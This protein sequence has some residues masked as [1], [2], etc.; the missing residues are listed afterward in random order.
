MTKEMLGP[1]IT[2]PS[3]IIMTEGT[4]GDG[5]ASLL[6][7]PLTDLFLFYLALYG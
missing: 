5:P 3:M 4:N 2:I 7:I 1:M 6:A